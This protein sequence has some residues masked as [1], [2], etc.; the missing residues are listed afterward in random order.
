MFECRECG[1]EG[2]NQ[3]H[4]K[5]YCNNHYDEVRSK[6]IQEGGNELLH[7]YESE[8]VCPHCG[9]E[10]SDS[11]EMTDSGVEECENCC[12]EFKFER[13]VEVTYSTYKLDIDSN[14]L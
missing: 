11:W 5:Y 2:Y 4:G 6:L 3:L 10:Y 8:I 7:T 1:K 14:E 9:Y 13:E 12:K